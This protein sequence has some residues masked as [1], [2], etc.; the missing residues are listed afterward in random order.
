LNRRAKCRDH[1]WTRARRKLLRRRAIL[2]TP[3]FLSLNRRFEH[4]HRTLVMLSN[5]CYW[6]ERRRKQGPTNGAAMLFSTTRRGSRYGFGTWMLRARG[7]GRYL[8]A[9]T[10]AHGGFGVRCTGHLSRCRD[11]CARCTARSFAR[12]NRGPRPRFLSRGPRTAAE[13]RELGVHACD[14]PAGHTCRCLH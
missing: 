12:R 6:P 3:H 13:R 14:R 4:F 10:L 7:L 9:A 8:C 1:H 11:S 2:R 5:R